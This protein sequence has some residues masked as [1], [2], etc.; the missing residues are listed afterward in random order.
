M[1]EDK[2]NVSSH[3]LACDVNKLSCITTDFTFVFFLC[4]A[5]QIKFGRDVK[6]MFHGR[7]VERMCVLVR[8][9][10]VNRD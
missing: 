5:K 10:Q 3:I 6:Q 2:S 7:S 1:Y 8:T 4:L 9:E